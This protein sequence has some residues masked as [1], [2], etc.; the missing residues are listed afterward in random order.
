[1]PDY[2]RFRHPLRLLL[3]AA[4]SL[5]AH[6][7][8][9]DDLE[10]PATRTD[11]AASYLLLD[12][13]EAG[14]RLVA[15]GARGHVIYSDDQGESW[16]QANVPVSTALTAVDFVDEKRGWAVGHGGVVLHSSDGGE[17]WKRQFDGNDANEFVIKGARDYADQLEEAFA[18]AS[19]KVEAAEESGSQSALAEVADID[20]DEMEFQL[21]DAIFALEDAEIDA[22]AGATKPMLDVLFLDE[23]RGFA[24]GAFGFFFDTRDGGE[25]WEYRAASIEN[26]DRF[27]LNAITQLDENT[28]LIVGEAG[29]MFRSQD[30]GETWEMLESVYDGSFFGV[31]PTGEADGVLVYGLRGNAYLSQDQGDTWQALELGVTETL[32]ASAYA[33][34]GKVALVGNA[35]M[36]LLSQDGGESFEANPRAD[37]KALLGAHYLASDRLLLVGEGGVSLIRDLSQLN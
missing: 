13:D 4:I 25:T 7:V 34:D 19:E 17:N 18:L 8:A 10:T 28:L 11:Q 23:Q 26:V 35:G 16:I 20:L 33:S 15:V 30:A 37:R 21:E 5:P 32:M 12:L 9:S 6:A 2:L 1:M 36:L 31:G 29:Q 24:I 3:A 14:N 22:E 27:H